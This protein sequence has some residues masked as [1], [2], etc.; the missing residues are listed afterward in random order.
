MHIFRVL[1]NHQK[2]DLNQIK[3]ITEKSDLNQIKTFEAV[4]LGVTF[5]AH[6]IWDSLSR[7]K[8]DGFPCIPADHS[9]YHWWPQY[10]YADQ[11]SRQVPDYL[12][13]SGDVVDVKPGVTPCQ[14]DLNLRSFVFLPEH[15]NGIIKYKLYNTVRALEVVSS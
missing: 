14:Q 8:S 4:L 1:E 12:I 3:I 5:S 13:Q 11:V 6:F 7:H 15:S 2:V 10:N 9:A